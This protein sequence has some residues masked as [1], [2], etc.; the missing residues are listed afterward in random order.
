MPEGLIHDL[1]NHTLHGT[2]SIGTKKHHANIKLNKVMDK[3]YFKQS[4]DLGGPTLVL[5]DTD[6]NYLKA[7]AKI[8]I[9]FHNMVLI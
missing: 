3:I 2:A 8:N 9:S 1:S 4:I 5:N 6:Y 7:H